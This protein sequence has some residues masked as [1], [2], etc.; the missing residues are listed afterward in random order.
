MDI[1]I[2]S[3][4]RREYNGKDRISQMN[5]EEIACL[6][7]DKIFEYDNSVQ[8]IDKFENK[9]LHDISSDL[10]WTLCDGRTISIK[11]EIKQ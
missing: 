11:I 4:G 7:E 9:R 5:K 8:D 1:E 6:I 2:N 10:E 3:N